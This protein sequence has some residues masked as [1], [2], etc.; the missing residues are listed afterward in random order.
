MASQKS[1]KVRGKKSAKSEEVASVTGDLAY[2]HLPGDAEPAEAR[3][4]A[5]SGLVMK[6]LGIRATVSLEDLPVAVHPLLQA[7]APITS[8]E[9]NNAAQRILASEQR[10][11]KV[12]DTPGG[13]M[14]ISGLLEFVACFF[15]GKQA[16]FTMVAPPDN[17]EMFILRERIPD[18]I[19]NAQRAAM[20]ALTVEHFAKIAR[21][22][23]IEKLRKVRTD[24]V[25]TSDDPEE[26]REVRAT[27]MAAAAAQVS[28]GDVDK[29][30]A[31]LRGQ[32]KKGRPA[33][34][35]IFN[36]MMNGT[37]DTMTWPKRIADEKAFDTDDKKIGAM[38]A[39]STAGF[40]KAASAYRD[41]LRGVKMPDLGG[42][43][44][45]GR[46]ERYEVLHGDLRE[47]GK[48]L[49]DRSFDRA[50]AD[51]L[52]GTP[53]NPDTCEEIAKLWARVGR[54]GAIICFLPGLG[55]QV[56]CARRIAK[57]LTYVCTGNYRMLGYRNPLPGFLDKIEDMCLWYFCVGDRPDVPLAAQS[58]ES[59]RPQAPLDINERNL[60]SIVTI[61]K[62][63][64][65]ERGMRVLDP[66]CCTGTTLIAAMK[67]E[68]AQVVGIE[69]EE[70]RVTKALNRC[71]F[72][73]REGRDFTEPA[74][75]AV[76]HPDAMEPV[77]AE[78]V[79]I[80]S[81]PASEQ[82][83]G[84]KT[85]EFY[86][87]AGRELLQAART[88]LELGTV[89][90]SIIDAKS[91]LGSMAAKAPE[92]AVTIFVK[93]KKVPKGIDTLGD[94]QQAVLHGRKGSGKKKR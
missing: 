46:G 73:V 45:E 70:E 51:P 34:P 93:G 20:A 68:C 27:T 25:Q 35:L 54:E 5:G 42:G 37:F 14:I 64:K 38:N 23:K 81:D 30:L 22:G 55:D 10:V 69:L 44:D 59:A 78:E 56:E 52:W 79:V 17:L 47:M 88:D 89:L 43:K 77:G 4:G 74:T 76:A 8:W 9:L 13:P 72:Y 63:M 16:S 60:D 19:T 15:L 39:V 36:A 3:P 33:S 66:V 83:T 21:A 7:M 2:P 75:K 61:L 31:I 49:D 6:P 40:A 41:Y 1:P 71:A 24:R 84:A 26:K 67:L 90:T 85:A 82:T 62:N 80:V 87:T 48:G 65:T 18:Q 12:I 58:T 28:R 32:P 53:Q 91:H 92:Y 57:H 86:R 11:I 94:L 50:F 29:A